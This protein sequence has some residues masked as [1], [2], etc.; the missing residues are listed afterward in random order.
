[1]DVKAM[2]N[3][4]VLKDLPSN[5]VEEAFVVL[6]KNVKIHKTEVLENNKKNKGVTKASNSNDFVIKEAELVL[7]EYIDKIEIKNPIKLKKYE[8]DIS[9]KYKRLK[10]LT[11]FLGMFS[12][13]L[14]ILNFIK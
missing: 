3:M 8:K 10:A 9:K 1:M 7:Q 5:V 4:V 14:S 12:A 6:K 11:I 2:K 13:I